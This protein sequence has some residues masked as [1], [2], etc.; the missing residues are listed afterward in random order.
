MQAV[1]GRRRGAEGAGTNLQPPQLGRLLVCLR[2]AHRQPLLQLLRERRLTRALQLR[3]CELTP[4]LE[5][6]GFQRRHVVGERG[7][8]ALPLGLPLPRELVEA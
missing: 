1:Q 4:R 3:L 7:E 5:K 6:R 2:V 8:E